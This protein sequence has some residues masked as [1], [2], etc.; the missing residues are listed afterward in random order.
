MEAAMGV[1]PAR[2]GLH[3]CGPPGGKA[4][5]LHAVLQKAESAITTQIRTG[6]IGLTAFLNKARLPARLKRMNGKKNDL[7]SCSALCGMEG[8]LIADCLQIS[9]GMLQVAPFQWERGI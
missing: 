8:C 1:R 7:L 4:V 3:R 6:R 2:T 9:P 5:K